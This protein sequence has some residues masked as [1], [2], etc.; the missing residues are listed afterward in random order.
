LSASYP[1]LFAGTA[2]PPLA[3]RVA[4]LLGVPLSGCD[5]QRFPDGEVSVVLRDSVRH[6]DAFVIQPT[7]PPVDGNL[8]ELLAFG[9]AC[10]RAGA[11]RVIAVVSYF[12]YGRSDR[13]S[14]KREPI[15][16]GMVAACLEAVGFTHVITVDMHTPQIEGF[17]RIPVDSLS[18]MPTLA[19]ELRRTLPEQAVVVAPD[20]G[21]V[22]TATALADLLGIE[23]VILHKRRESGS[24][25]T[26]RA[27]IGDVRGRAC[28]LIDDMISTGGTIEESIAAL[29]RHGAGR[30]MIVA[31]THGLFV[32]NAAE[33]LRD[34]TGIVVTDTTLVRWERPVVCSVATLIADAIRRMR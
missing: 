10:H 18:A 5:V 30:E 25:T 22:K 12:G 9:D 6:R 15:G 29:R 24:E 28:I 1:A 31:A 26:V 11:E 19:D 21:R 20:A 3:A 7:A 34:A 13:R 16:A 14:D 4:E 2:N 33:R 32:G 27:I 8:V 17:F 23:L